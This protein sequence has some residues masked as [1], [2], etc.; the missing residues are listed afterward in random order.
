MAAVIVDENADPFERDAEHPRNVR[1]VALKCAQAGFR[2]KFGSSVDTWDDAWLGGTQCTALLQKLALSYNWRADTLRLAAL[3]SGARASSDKMLVTLG[4]TKT[5]VALMSKEAGTSLF[6]SGQKDKA[7]VPWYV[8]LHYLRGASTVLCDLSRAYAKRVESA[9]GP[10]NLA[11]VRTA[12]AAYLLDPSE[13]ETRTY[14]KTLPPITPMATERDLYDLQHAGAVT[15]SEM[16]EEYQKLL[17]ASQ[18]GKPGIEAELDGRFPSLV[19]E[20]TECRLPGLV[21]AE[22]QQLAKEIQAYCS[23]KVTERLLGGDKLT[24]QFDDAWPNLNQMYGRF[25][26]LTSEENLFLWL[27][28]TVKVGTLFGGLK[29]VRRKLHVL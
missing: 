13:A 16:V 17:Q 9:G 14:L 29:G 27:D 24:G 20:L 15:G 4:F 5:K 22:L 18:K 10:H 1:R 2:D 3:S 6:R 25:G 12:V 11:A 21:D 28:E 7:V 23:L 26:G 19:E 8:A